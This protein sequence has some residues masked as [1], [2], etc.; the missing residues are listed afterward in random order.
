MLG[1]EVGM[2]RAINDQYEAGR[3]LDSHL[4]GPVRNPYSSM[5][6]TQMRQVTAHRSKLRQLAAQIAESANFVCS[7][8][9]VQRYKLCGTP[10]CRC[11]DD[12]P[13][14]HGPYWQW[15]YRPTGGKTVSRQVDQR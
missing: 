14:P 3:Q 12:T 1:R 13:Q 9:L 10:T 15:S 2:R 5:N 4:G 6:P 7:G 8:T 11:H